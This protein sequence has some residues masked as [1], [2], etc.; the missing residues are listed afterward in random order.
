[1][2]EVTNKQDIVEPF[3]T[4]DLNIDHDFSFFYFK[5]YFSDFHVAY[6]KVPYTDF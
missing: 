5:N 2:K 3:R 1:M 4:D 6:T